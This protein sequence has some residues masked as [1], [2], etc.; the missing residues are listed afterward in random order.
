MSFLSIFTGYLCVYCYLLFV[1]PRIT[2]AASLQSENFKN[3]FQEGHVH[4][5]RGGQQGETLL[6]LLFHQPAQDDGP[7][8]I[9]SRRDVQPG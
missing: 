4:A 5:R 6:P 1:K 3:W 9:L 7:Y 2:S 8:A